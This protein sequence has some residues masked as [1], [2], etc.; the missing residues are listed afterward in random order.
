MALTLPSALALVGITN[1]DRRWTLRALHSVFDSKF[2]MLAEAIK[3]FEAKTTADGY[4]K[5][6]LLHA[7]ALAPSVAGAADT[8]VTITGVSMLGSRLVKAAKTLGTGTSSLAF[9]AVVPG[10]DGNDITI[11]VTPSGGSLTVTANVS[12]KTI[13]VTHTNSTAAQIASGINSDAAAKFL[14]NCT[15]GGSGTVSATYTAQKLTGG[16]GDTPSLSVGPYAVNGLIAGWGVTNWTS[17]VITFDMNPTDTDGAG[18]NMAIGV[19]HP[20]R[21]TID[22]YTQDVGLCVPIT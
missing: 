5:V 7:D 19:G 17:T 15:G 12:A 14:V 3:N 13:V 22:G 2:D 21:L 1:F 16:V 8:G 9:E 18:A 6:T 11:S 10:E 4:A 20:I